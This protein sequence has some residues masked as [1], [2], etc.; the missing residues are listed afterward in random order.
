MKEN[1]RRKKISEKKNRN[2]ATQ[3]SYKSIYVA[4]GHG[5]KPHHYRKVSS[6]PPDLPRQEL[7]NI[8]ELDKHP[9]KIIFS[10]K[11]RNRRIARARKI[12]RRKRIVNDW[13]RR[14]KI[15]PD[16]L[17]QVWGKEYDGTIQARAD[18]LWKY[19]RSII[20]ATFMRLKQDLEQG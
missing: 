7:R 12:S 5:K 11:E 14:L 20:Y 17:V 6:F 18:K 2:K 10:S 13:I 16:T 9:E 19:N 15:N 4:G 8:E 1:V 3:K